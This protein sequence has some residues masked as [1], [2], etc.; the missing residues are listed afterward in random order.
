[1]YFVSFVRSKLTTNAMLVNTTKGIENGPDPGVLITL[2]VVVVIV[3]VMIIGLICVTM[4]RGS[5]TSATTTVPAA[6]ATTT[7]S[8]TPMLEDDRL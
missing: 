8:T 3:L 1:M 6:A 5:E 2:G 4:P 7:A